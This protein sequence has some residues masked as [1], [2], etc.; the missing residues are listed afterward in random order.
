MSEIHVICTKK[1]AVPMTRQI[2]HAPS[3]SA[4]SSI[5]CLPEKSFFATSFT[6]GHMRKAAANPMALPVRS[7]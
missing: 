5:Q 7:F 1:S 2:F 4:P 6:S 3:L